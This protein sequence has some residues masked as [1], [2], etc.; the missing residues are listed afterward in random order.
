[1][2][3]G[4]LMIV[5]VL[6][7]GTAC[8]TGKPAPTPSDDDRELMGLAD[9]PL[10]A[11]WE[12]W[13]PSDQMSTPPALTTTAAAFD[14]WQISDEAVIDEAWIA[15]SAVVSNV[16]N[17]T[18]PLYDD[19][20]RTLMTVLEEN[21]GPRR[22]DVTFVVSQ[23]DAAR[24]WEGILVRVYREMPDGAS[25]GVSLLLRRRAGGP[26]APRDARV[27]FFSGFEEAPSVSLSL[28]RRDDQWLAHISEGVVLEASQRVNL[29]A[30][31]VAA[32][33]TQ[34]FWTPYTGNAY[35]EF[36]AA[37]QTEHLA[38]P[39]THPLS[40]G[41]PLGDRDIEQVFSDSVFAPRLTG[42]P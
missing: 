23:R 32:V 27:W 1:M 28:A 8:R 20:F 21:E 36:N 12:S 39:A 26:D 10:T 42:F 17:D 24:P 4:Q 14:Y 6:L 29:D 31:V 41:I 18:A 37:R 33:L 30:S 7:T 13:T 38:T 11:M 35:L 34:T 3:I 40:A 16:R 5:L 25:P 19:T 15:I 22:L 9:R 2:R